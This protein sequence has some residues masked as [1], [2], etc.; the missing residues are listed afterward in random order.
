MK[1]I[2]LAGGLAAVAPSRIR[3]IADVAFGMDGVLKL[4]FGESNLPTPPFIKEAAV[5]ALNEGFTFYTENAGLPGL[6]Q[7]IAQYKGLQPVHPQAV[8]DDDRRGA[9][10]QRSAGRLHRQLDP[11]VQL[12]EL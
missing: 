5:R 10:G 12:G 3:E 4:H 9:R 7:A 6:R 1:K 11:D 8:H 2:A